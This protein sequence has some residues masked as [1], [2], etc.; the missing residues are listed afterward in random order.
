[1]STFHTLYISTLEP[2]I[3]KLDKQRKTATVAGFI[4]RVFELYFIT[5]VV[6][7]FLGFLDMF[8]REAGANDGFFGAIRYFMYFVLTIVVVGL[9]SAQVKKRLGEI[10]PKLALNKTRVSILT[11]VF[12][13]VAIAGGY[14]IG[15]LF[16]GAEFGMN[17]MVKWILAIASVF[18]MLGPYYLI[19]KLEDRFLNHFKETLFSVSLPAIDKKIEYTSDNGLVQD[20]FVQSKLF[21]YQKIDT[22]KSRDYFANADKSFEGSFMDVMQVEHTQSNGKSE[23]KYSQL[24]KGYLFV[25]DFNK[26]TTG[27]TYIFPDNA[28]MIFG[29][30][31]AERINE[32]IHRPALQLAL[33]EDIEFEKYFAV[34]TTDPVEARYILS[35]KLIERITA[36]KNHFYQDVQMSFVGNKIYL[37]ISSTDDL[38]APGVFANLHDEATIEKFYERLHLLITFPEQFDLATRVWG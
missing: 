4:C 36:F 17:F 30:H 1:M 22:F 35:P 37:A 14:F 25:T 13:A 2:A 15:T 3:A 19:K 21:T 16:L 38:F 20:Q 33:M 6:S 18:V 31:T 8:S 32:L 7:L 27:E 11:L 26:Q 29:E 12:S 23:T 10:D 34:Y 28:R 5:L 9:I 24:F